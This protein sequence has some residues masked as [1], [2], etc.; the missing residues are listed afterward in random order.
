MDHLD[1]S[2]GLFQCVIMIPYYLTI[3]SRLSS[4][5]MI[6]SFASAV[7]SSR[8]AVDAHSSVLEHQ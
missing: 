8:Q 2:M 4:Q 7:T 6:L 1:D 3:L 5:K